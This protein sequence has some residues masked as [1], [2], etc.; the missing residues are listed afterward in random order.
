[1]C[2]RADTANNHKCSGHLEYFKMLND[3]RVAYSSFIE[4]TLSKTFWYQTFYAFSK[5]SYRPGFHTMYDKVKYS[6]NICSYL[7]FYVTDVA[8]F[9]TIDEQLQLNWV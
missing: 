5:V 9:I 2:C 7:R 3:A 6:S 8:S 1:M 4:K